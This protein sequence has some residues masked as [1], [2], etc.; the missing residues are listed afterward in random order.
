MLGVAR[1]LGIVV[2]VKGVVQ[3][4]QLLLLVLSLVVVLGFGLSSERHSV[5]QSLGNQ[6]RTLA[7][8]AYKESYPDKDRNTKSHDPLRKGIL[9]ERYGVSESPDPLGVVRRSVWSGGEVL[10]YLVFKAYG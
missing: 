3:P 4:T 9:P 1:R 5:L 8:S 2:V 7:I 6:Q 10:L